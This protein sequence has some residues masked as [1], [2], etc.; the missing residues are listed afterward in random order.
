MNILDIEYKK[1]LKYVLDHGEQRPDRTGTG[2]ISVFSP[3]DLVI[4]MSTHFPLLTSRHIPIK[5]ITHESIWMFCK[6]ST[7]IKYLQDN[8]VKVWNEW[9]VEDGELGPIYGSN[10]RAFQGHKKQQIEYLDQLQNAIN[11]L[12]INKYSR[13]HLISGWNPV[14]IPIESLSFQDN[15]NLGRSVLPQCHGV[16]IQFYV[17]NNNE[18]SMKYYIRSS[19]LVLGFPAN[20]INSGLLLRM[21]AQVTG[22]K[23][24]KL[25]ITFGDAHIY[26]DHLEGVEKL[27]NT[28]E[29][30]DS[31]TLSINPNITDIDDFTFEDFIFSEYKYSQK[32]PFQVS[33]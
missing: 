29:V 20:C 2:I 33:V 7:N 22:Y 10:F 12:K 27:L 28:H 19:D 8:N 31:P 15:Y 4:D 6:G 30:L 13:R 14:T 17:S 3:P 11:L 26:N 21:V 1:L 25:I 9:A 5:S 32:I 24:H 18:L 16:I 23:P